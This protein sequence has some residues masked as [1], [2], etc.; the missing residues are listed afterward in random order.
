M[1]ECCGCNQKNQ[2]WTLSCT[3]TP[4]SPP[5]DCHPP[6]SHT[7]NENTHPGP[8]SCARCIR[9]SCRPSATPAPSIARRTA[10]WA[11]G[12]SWPRWRSMWIRLRSSSW[13]R[14][15][16]SGPDPPP[17]PPSCSRSTTSSSSSSN[18]SRSTTSSSSNTTNSSSS[19]SRHHS[20][21]TNERIQSH[22]SHNNNSHCNNN[23][24]NI[25]PLL[26]KN[27]LARNRIIRYPS[28]TLV[29]S[30]RKISTLDEIGPPDSQ[31]FSSS[32]AVF[33][34]FCNAFVT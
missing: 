27:C 5:N 8:A 2:L 32:R 16:R 31:R 10:A 12:S 22:R 14:G 25:H 17:P 1:L 19:S 23:A 30:D 13:V 29:R 28:E 21:H 11:N 6:T 15:H 33:V 9:S 34:H 18:S 3:C 20:N 4:I 26:A 7:P 24:N